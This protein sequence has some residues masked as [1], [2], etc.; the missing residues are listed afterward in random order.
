MPYNPGIEYRGDRYIAQGLPAAAGLLSEAGLKAL[1]DIDETQKKKAFG[2]A[3]MTHLSQMPSPTGEPYVPLEMLAKYHDANT[4]SQAGMVQAAMA[5]AASDLQMQT[6]ARQNKLADAQIGYYDARAKDKLDGAD[7]SQIDPYID[8]TTGEP[9]PNMGIVRKT[10]SVVKTGAADDSI[11]KLDKDVHAITGARLGD[12]T[13]ATKKELSK[14]GKFLTAEIPG[15]ADIFGKQQPSKTVKL[16]VSQYQQFI[17]RYNNLA[18]AGGTGPLTPDPTA[19]G[20]AIGAGMGAASGL[21]VDIPPVTAPAPTTAPAPQ[22]APGTKVKQNGIVYQYD[23][24]NW[25]AVH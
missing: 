8:P 18:G 1:N 12:W 16:P 13:N 25:T 15:K 17:N 11:Q 7:P 5:N 24:A 20:G 2:D 23:G 9:L 10:G 22:I 6:S 19:S 3:V 4:N 14:D 21:P